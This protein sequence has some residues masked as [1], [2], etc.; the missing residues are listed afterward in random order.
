MLSL[1]RRL[2]TAVILLLPC[3]FIMGC[4]Y[5]SHHWY[6]ILLTIP[7][8]ILL[9]DVCFSRCKYDETIITIRTGQYM[10]S[11]TYHW[12]DFKNVKVDRYYPW[13]RIALIKN[14]NRVVYAYCDNPLSVREVM[15]NMINKNKV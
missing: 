11:R 3:I 8:L 15:V 12:S 9:Y 13:G 10:I 14:D 2:T 4:A 7:S 5:W 1:K 6:T